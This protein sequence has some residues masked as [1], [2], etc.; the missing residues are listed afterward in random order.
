[1]TT[2]QVSDSASNRDEQI[3]NAGEILK[4]ASARQIVFEAVYRGKKQDKT[5]GEIAIATGYSQKRV[6]MIAGPLAHQGLFQQSRKRVG[7]SKQTVYSK[8]DFIKSNRSKILQL[9]RS[10]QKR[11]KFHTKANPKVNIATSVNIRVPKAPKPRFV[12]IDEV[13]QFSKVRKVNGVPQKLSP[14]RLPELI[15][16]KGILKLL[17]ETKIPKDWGGESNDIFSAK[18]KIKGKARRAAFALKGPAK[19][20][21]LVPAM[22][23]KN[24]DQIQRLFASPAEV[25]FVQYEGDIAESIVTQMEQLAIAKSVF[26]KDVLFGTIDRDDTYRLRVAYKNNFS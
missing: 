26:V 22:M 3:K 20:G 7:G 25:F 18:L 23:G 13:E 21:T 19:Q 12:K 5:A 6:T 16:K 2:L 10:K 11:D 8:I 15:V 14:E 1:M 9:A 4:N 17:K 24:G